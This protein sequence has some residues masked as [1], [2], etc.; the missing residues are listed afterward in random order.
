M[1]IITYGMGVHWAREAVDEMGVD[2]E[3]IDLRTLLPWD[4]ETVADSVKKTGR[5]LILHEDTLTGGVGAELA[6]WIA[7][8]CFQYLDAPVFRVASLDTPVPFAAPLEQNFLP[9]GRLR[10]RIGELMK[11]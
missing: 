11:F 5:V 8:T 4:K 1:S 2:A 10:A 6:A 9:K 7:E 3:I